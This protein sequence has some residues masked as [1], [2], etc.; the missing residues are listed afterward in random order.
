[1]SSGGP[2]F[3]RGLRRDGGVSNVALGPEPRSGSANMNTVRVNLGERSYDIVVTSDDLAGLGPFA[4]Q[5]TRGGLAVVIA[6]E[7]VTDHAGRASS[8]LAGAG[9]RTNTILIPPGE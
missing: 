4:R 6:D 3:A 1:M 5:R 7:H 8:A 9:F 2:L